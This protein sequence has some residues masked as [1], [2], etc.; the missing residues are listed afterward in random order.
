MTENRW[1]NLALIFFMSFCSSLSA[2]PECALFKNKEFNNGKAL[3]QGVQEGSPIHGEVHFQ[4]SSEGLH[5]HAMITGLTPG[6]HGFHIHEFGDI[7]NNGKAAGGHYN[8]MEKPHG[9]VVE[10]GIH[11]VH[12][13]DL[14]NI[15][16][17]SSGYGELSVVVKDLWL[18]GKP[19]SI[20]GRA[21]I[22]HEKEDDFGQ[23]VGNAGARMAGGT[24]LLVDE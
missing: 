4:E 24:I 13:G 23:P 9:Y 22:I 18:T 11:A 17:D 19:F 7:S 10:Q 16:V 21:V 8:P 12:G 15:E 3:I 20:A 6:K 1:M 14:G 2:G 5:V